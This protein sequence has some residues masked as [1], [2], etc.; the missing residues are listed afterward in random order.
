MKFLQFSLYSLLL[1]S[2]VLIT[3]C[4]DDIDFSGDHV[5]TPVLFGLLDKSDSLHY[6]KITRTFSGSN[7]SLLVAQI[8]D[9]SYFQDVNI[10]IEEWVPLGQNNASTLVRS[11]T[12]QD[13]VLKNKAPGAFYSPNQKVYFFKTKT[14]NP[15]NQPAPNDGNPTTALKQEATYKMTATVNG[16]QIVVKGETKLVSAM[17]ITSPTGNG[18]YSF[19]KMVGGV[20]QY[21]VPSLKANVGNSEVVDARIQFFFNEYIN[22][23]PIQ[24][25]FTWKVGEMTGSEITG[26]SVSFAAN[27]ETFYQLVAQNCTNDPSITKREMTSIR[28]IMT[29][30]SD[31]LAKYILVNKPSSSLAQNKPSFTNLTRTDGGPVVGLF[32]SR[33]TNRLDKLKYNPALPSQR[34]LDL[35]SLRELCIG[36][37]TG[38]FGFC[39]DNPIDINNGESWV[40]Q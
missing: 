11:W 21:N 36:P 8:E 25:S 2:L 9:S 3:S 26:E 20:K 18:N 16:G 34:A 5:E 24:K 19:V 40:C 7:N 38:L 30:G 23:A 10:V 14:F 15:L 32:S 39:S 4:E 27:G 35:L 31:D 12:L 37:I 29:G 1:T 6:V 22:G 28:L 17:S 33:M 13:T